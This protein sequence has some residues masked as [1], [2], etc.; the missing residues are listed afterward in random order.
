MTSLASQALAA[1]CQP[2]RLEG[3]V[4]FHRDALVV[5]IPRNLIGFAFT[6]K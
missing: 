6:S 3:V 4:Q 2:S 5:T 1:V